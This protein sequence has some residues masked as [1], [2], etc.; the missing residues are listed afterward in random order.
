MTFWLVSSFH[1]WIFLPFP[2]PFPP[3]FFGWFFLHSLQG[4]K[5][6][7]GT[8]FPVYMIFPPV[9][10]AAISYV[11]SWK[12]A[13]PALP[14][15]TAAHPGLSDEDAPGSSGMQDEPQQRWGSG[16]LWSDHSSLCRNIIPFF[17]L[18]FSQ[19]LE[20]LFW[21]PLASASGSF[22][23]SRMSKFSPELQEPFA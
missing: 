3:P 19:K 22:S 7:T 21:I 15:P 18:L 5:S 10:T 16:A 9:P 13:L 17:V 14:W 11:P 23:S 12:T 1:L 6:A 20:N 2:S 8:N 4:G